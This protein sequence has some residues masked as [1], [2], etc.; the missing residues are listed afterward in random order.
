MRLLSLLC[1]LSALFWLPLGS[2]AQELKCRVE[3]NTQQLQNTSTET[4]KTLADAITSY[5]NDT[6]FTQAQI[7]SNER[8][9][10]SLLFTIAEYEDNVAKGDLQIQ[11]TRPI[12]NASITTPL[13]NWRDTKIEFS[14]TQ[15]EP[16]V[17]NE[18]T[19]TSNLTAILDYYAFL[20]MAVDFDSFAQRGGEDLFQ[21]LAT[22]VQRAQSAGETGWKA[23]E[24]NRNRSA[25]LS[26]FTDPSTAALRDLVYAYHRKGLDEMA[27]S[28]DKGR[29]AITEALGTLREIYDRD[30][31]NVALTLFHDTKLDELTNIYSVCRPEE[32]ETVVKLIS[33]LYP[34]DNDAV[35]RIKNPPKRN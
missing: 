2:A 13:L 22:I 27:V 16:L 7:A 33:D 11:V 12:Y 34:T 4:F 3:V 30:P 14:Y 29:A 8:I 21:H 5:M 31:M 10:C 19:M 35:D 23:F 9:E 20:I 1:T 18:Q 6:K 25:V 28:P 17:Y 26:A 24:D 32:K 15:G